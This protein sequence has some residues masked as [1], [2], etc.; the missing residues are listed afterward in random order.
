MTDTFMDLY[1]IVKRLDGQGQLTADEQK[2]LQRVNEAM[3]RYSTFGPLPE[4]T[5][6]NPPKKIRARF[7]GYKRGPNV[8]DEPLFKP[9]QEIVVIDESEFVEGDK[10]YIGVASEEDADT[11]LKGGFVDGDELAEGEFEIIEMAA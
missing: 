9:G 3:A 4:D 11:H 2:V 7:T 8:R 1:N 5:D 6:S 10:V